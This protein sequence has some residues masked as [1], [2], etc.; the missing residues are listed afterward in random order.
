MR[1]WI[2]GLVAA[3]L[4]AIALAVAALVLLRPGDDTIVLDLDAGDCFQVPD[5]IARATVSKV[6]TID[7]TKPHEA[8]TSP[9]PTTSSSCSPA[10]T[11]NARPSSPAMP[12]SSIASACCPSWPTNGRGRATA[13]AMSASPF[14]T[15]AAR[16]KGRSGSELMVGLASSPS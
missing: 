6:D 5:D 15:A 1:R 3:S 12:I 11:V 7:C 2:V 13:D 10:S 8:E 4:V 9:T 14:P 16:R